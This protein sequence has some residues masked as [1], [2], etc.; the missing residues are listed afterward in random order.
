M[1]NTPEIEPNT[2]S[3]RNLLRRGKDVLLAVGF[4]GMSGGIPLLTEACSGSENED[5]LSRE[6]FTNQ[7]QS[8]IDLALGRN[9][10]GNHFYLYEDGSPWGEPY[11]SYRI[12]FFKN[13]NPAQRGSLIFYPNKT[14]RIEIQDT[15]T[16]QV[17]NWSIGLDEEGKTVWK[18]SGGEEGEKVSHPEWNLFRENIEDALNDASS[19]YIP[20]KQML[21]EPSSDDIEYEQKFIEEYD[22]L[23][24]RALKEDFVR[25]EFWQSGLDSKSSY[26]IAEVRKDYDNI[27]EMQSFYYKRSHHDDLLDPH[28]RFIWFQ[29]GDFQGEVTITSGPGNVRWYDRSE[30]QAGRRLTIDEMQQV[31]NAMNRAYD[32]AAL[33][34]SL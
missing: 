15:T 9:I 26:V 27:L 18:Y 12:K 10:P 22:R 2:L 8:F 6:R 4:I 31:L 11:E 14:V 1:A 24:Q 32:R 7:V 3:R 28:S 13:L 29:D 17:S 16:W 33:K 30:Q 5:T 21:V 34:A 20:S 19:L 25:Q 23:L